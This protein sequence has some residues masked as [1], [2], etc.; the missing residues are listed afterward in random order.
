MTWPK[1][2]IP[3]FWFVRTKLF[4]RSCFFLWLVF[5]CACQQDIAPS[6]IKTPA[7]TVQKLPSRDQLFQE[8][9]NR[10]KI[11]YIYS[12]SIDAYRTLL[13]T[14]QPGRRGTT[15]QIIVSSQA[16]SRLLEN[17]IVFLLGSHRTNTWIKK[18]SGLLPVEFSPQGF[19]FDEKE[20][21]KKSDAIKLYVYPNPLNP[22]L[23]LFLFTGNEDQAIIT[24]LQE[25]NI[26]NWDQLVWRSKGYEV[27]RNQKAQIMGYFNDTSWVMDKE[28]HFDFAND[29]D[30]LLQTAHF[31]FI[32]KPSIL[33]STSLKVLAQN[34]EQTYE[35]I[36][37]FVGREPNLPRINY[38]LYSS[39]EEKGLQLQNTSTAHCDVKNNCVFVVTSNQI[40]GQWEH[41]EHELLLRKMLGK[42]QTKAL[43]TGTR[44]YHSGQ[45]RGNGYQYWARRLHDAESLPSLETLV[46]NKTF[47]AGSS[48]IMGTAAAVLVDFLTQYW[49]P[50]AFLHNYNAWSPT[51]QEIKDLEKKW[52]AFLNDYEII[53]PVSN[54]SQERPY[55]KGFNFAHEGY[56]IY[57]GYGSG[58]ARQSLT[59]LQRLGSN[60]VAI[61]PYSYMRNPTVPSYFSPE[62]GAGGE[63]DEAV[64][65]AHLN[66]KEL[67]MY[68]MLKPQIW[69]GR[70]WPGDVEMSSEEDWR[71]F[72]R[73]YS[74]W[75]MHYALLAEMYDF[76]LF[77]VGVEFAKA[78]VQRPGDWRA[79]IQRIRK[80]YNGPITY[81]ANWGTEFEQ[82]SFWD[83]FDYIGLN[84]YYPLS[85]EVQPDKRA[86]KNKFNEVLALAEQ[87]SRQ[88]Q[89]PLLFT[90]IGFRSVDT[91]WKNPHADANGRSFNPEA[92]NLCY[93]VVFEGI[94]GKE[95]CHGIFWWKWPSYL[96]YRGIENTSF[97][98]NQKI[99]ER[100]V[101]KW[102]GRR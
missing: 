11:V 76:D 61:V 25:K 55:F 43:E 56:R 52:Y 53:P 22:D 87:V 23:P 13:E 2:Q 68:T 99:A 98:P 12:D 75:I 66:A 10:N 47:S 79:V 97:T 51:S 15:K 31:N 14:I 88:Y 4:F 36:Q 44:I 65:T 40:Q 67:G 80:V 6:Q 37:G 21:Q 77:C 16:D 1:F 63:N 3:D 54:D 26:D 35:K 34:C 7:P 17:E 45:W 86:L 72:F 95:W 19:V 60:A 20:Y 27:Y 24:L 70:S 100:T 41:P 28:I 91:P 5:F 74:E 49:G 93:E 85:E 90:E 94:E 9:R 83:E 64:I 101:Q 30:T 48:L 73:Y 78:T 29:I 89:K 59:K 82:F 42:P 58:L 39:V 32:G 57:N 102:F 84:C 33:E 18:L 62:H 50:E 96:G 46:D 81:A 8:L 92:Q 71:L 69:M 38:H